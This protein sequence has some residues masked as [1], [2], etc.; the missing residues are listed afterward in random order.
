MQPNREGF[1]ILPWFWFFLSS[2]ELI[3]HSDITLKRLVHTFLFC[4]NSF[5]WSSEKRE[6]AEADISLLCWNYR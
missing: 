5:L 2:E 4:N 1:L 3:Q 6:K